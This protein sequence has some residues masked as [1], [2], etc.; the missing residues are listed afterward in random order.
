[1]TTVKKELDINDCLV[2]DYAELNGVARHP[3][4]GIIP[5]FTV[6][7]GDYLTSYSPLIKDEEHEGVYFYLEY[8]DDEGCWDFDNTHHIEVE[9]KSDFMTL[10]GYYYNFPKDREF[11]KAY[12]DNPDLLI[13]FDSE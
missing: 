11:V 5:L 13:A 2:W 12:F 9:K 4:Y 10:T 1:M 8:N 6:Q 3:E 7:K